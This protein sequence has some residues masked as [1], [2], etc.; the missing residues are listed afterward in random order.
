M[1]SCFFLA[2]SAED[3]THYERY[4]SIPQV[5]EAADAQM[6]YIV[7]RT[8]KTFTDDWGRRLNIEE[9]PSWMTQQTRLAYNE[10]FNNRECG[11]ATKKDHELLDRIESGRDWSDRIERARIP[12]GQRTSLTGGIKPYPN[13]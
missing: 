3:G 5:Y 8:V 12:E 9:W 6:G 10:A 13:K 7:P 11:F 2:I 1:S 4:D